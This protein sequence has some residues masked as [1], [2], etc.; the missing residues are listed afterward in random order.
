MRVASGLKAA[1]VL[2]FVC[3][4]AP[5]YGGV[6]TSPSF[7]LQGH[8]GARGLRPEN[9]LLAF[10]EALRLG[11]STLEL[12]L[13]LT[14]DGVLVVGHDPRLSGDVARGPDGRFVEGVGPAI[15][16]LTYDEVQ[17]YDVGRLR[18]GSA[19]A[20]RFPEQKGA[21]GVRMPRLADVVA[22]AERAGNRSVRFNVEI[23]VDP[24][25]PE[26][27]APPA[28][29]AD[30]VVRFVRDRG[31]ASRVTIQSFDWRS[32]GRV[33][34]VAPEIERSCLTSEQPGDDTVQAG[35]PGPRAWLG[36]LEPRAFAG[37]VPR[38]V[39]A[40]QCQVW[41]PD[42]HDV[43]RE[44]VREAHA[45]GVTVLPWTCNE[46]ADMERLMDLGVDGMITDYPDRLRAVMARRGLPLPPATPVEP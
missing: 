4:G 26:A 21:D 30:A 6:V 33:R 5:G 16:F 11:V 29:F 44:R 36:G 12:D 14:R 19:Y 24:R 15:S 9:T 31:L 27:T 34:E 10:A 1:S 46:P 17:R 38:L 8:R 37:S 28:A 18:P 42:F 39:A 20:A 40:A 13:G 2:A 25:D 23:K 41:S 7:D 22:L 3:L 35:L 32:L 45:L 43:S